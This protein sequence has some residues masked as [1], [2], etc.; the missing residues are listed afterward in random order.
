MVVVLKADHCVHGKP[1]DD[2][3]ATE[4]IVAGVVSGVQGSRRGKKN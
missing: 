3:L 4:Q 2:G 1:G